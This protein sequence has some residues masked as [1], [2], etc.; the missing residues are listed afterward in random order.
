MDIAV[1][2]YKTSGL[3]V[4]YAPEAGLFSFGGCFEEAVNSLTEQLSA[5]VNA[6]QASAQNKTD[7]QR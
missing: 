5:Q 7:A 1:V 2:T 3:Y 6:L 4:S